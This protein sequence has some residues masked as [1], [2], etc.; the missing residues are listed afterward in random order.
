MVKVTTL[1]YKYP[2][3]GDHMRI[4]GFNFE[5]VR[6]ASTDPGVTQKMEESVGKVLEVTRHFKC[7]TKVMLSD[8]YIYNLAWLEPYDTMLELNNALMLL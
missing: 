4:V 3:I 2:S 6:G 5:F 8:G 1:S 7:N